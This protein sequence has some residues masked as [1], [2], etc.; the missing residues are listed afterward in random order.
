MRVLV[1]GG[2]GFLGRHVLQALAEAGHDPV[3]AGHDTPLPTEFRLVEQVEDLFSEVRPEAVVHLAGTA[4]REDFARGPVEVRTE[5]VSHPLLNVLEQA[6]RRRVVAVS[7][8]LVWGEG[9]LGDGVAPRPRD[10]YGAARATA[11]VMGA[12]RAQGDFLLLRPFLLLGEGAPACELFDARSAWHRAE[13]GV[14]VTPAHDAARAVV[15]SLER[16]VTGAAYTL[17]SGVTMRLGSLLESGRLRAAVV[18]SH[19]AADR[20]WSAPALALRA[21]GWRPSPDAGGVA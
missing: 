2:G 15:V 4:R 3:S 17:S 18:P 8:A 5:N 16:G 1:T 12:R 10:L 20:V 21:L 11:E 6:G 7:T 19:E 9:P 13:T 14:D